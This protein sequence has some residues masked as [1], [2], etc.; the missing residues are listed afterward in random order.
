MPNAS[1]ESPETIALVLGWF[2][3]L[4][5]GLNVLA[6]ARAGL[7]FNAARGLAH[8]V[9]RVLSWLALAAIFGILSVRAFGGQP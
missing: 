2:Y 4:C 9:V 7:S 6:A 5:S 3:V 1:P 8:R